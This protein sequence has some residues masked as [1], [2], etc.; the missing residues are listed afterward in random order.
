MEVLGRANSGKSTFM[1]ECMI[2]ALK[3]NRTPI[4][5]NSGSCES[6][7]KEHIKP[8]KVLSFPFST[9]SDVAM[10]LHAIGN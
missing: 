5:L 3:N 6:I 7:Y 2:E 4:L 9:L 1:A 10:L 8:H